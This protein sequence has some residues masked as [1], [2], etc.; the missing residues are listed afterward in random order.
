MRHLVKLI[1][2]P[3]DVVL[4]AFTGSGST[5]RGAVLE[6]CRFIG[7]ELSDTE[8]EPYVTIARRRIADAESKAITASGEA[9]PQDGQA[10]LPL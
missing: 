2:K 8:A 1:A 3:G 9:S 10:P 7:I 4:D 6:G 5:G